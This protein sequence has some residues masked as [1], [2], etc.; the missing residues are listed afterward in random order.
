MVGIVSVSVVRV[1]GL[2]LVLVMGILTVEKQTKESARRG[3]SLSGIC[4]YYVDSCFYCVAQKH[5]LVRLFS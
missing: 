5:L 2:V 4:F 1:L 3:T